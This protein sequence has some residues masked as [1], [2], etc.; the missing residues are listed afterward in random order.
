MFAPKGDIAPGF[1]ESE[2]NDGIKN[3]GFGDR[4][5]SQDN[6]LMASLNRVLSNPAISLPDKYMAVELYN[7]ADYA[8]RR[9]G[10]SS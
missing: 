3:G 4:D 9:Y 8:L 5:D 2:F 7:R 10:L 6:E 1:L